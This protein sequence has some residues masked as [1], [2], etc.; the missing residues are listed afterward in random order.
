MPHSSRGSWRDEWA[1]TSV[2]VAQMVSP[3]AWAAQQQISPLRYA[4]V[5]MTVLWV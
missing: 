5:E 2:R 1:C 3:Y 4:P